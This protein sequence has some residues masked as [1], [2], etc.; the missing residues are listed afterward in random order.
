MDIKTF[1]DTETF[2]LTYVVSDPSTSDAVVIEP[3]LDF[4]PPTC[5]TSTKSIDRVREYVSANSLKVRYILDTHAHADHMTGMD[6]LR[7]SFEA[8]TAMGKDIVAVQGLFGGVYNLPDLKTDGSQWDTLLSDGDV[9]NAGSVEVRAI[10]T[11][12]HTPACMSYLIGDAVFCGDALFMPD[13]GTGRCDFPKGS[14]SDLYNS[15]TTKLYKLP[16]ATRVFVGHDYMPN[17]RELA[18]ETTIGDSKE[19][20]IRLTANTTEAEFVSARE[21]RDRELAPPRLILQSLQVNIDAGRL[22]QAEDNDRRYLKMP[23]NFLGS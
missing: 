6:V 4:D 3:V 9:L 19:K 20:N 16:D 11:P 13:S 21:T 17:G 1:F 12:G 8:P 22:P 23:L 18:Y 14:A 5:R 7:E 2:T 10:H 15:V